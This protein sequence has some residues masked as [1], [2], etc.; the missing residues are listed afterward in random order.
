MLSTFTFSGIAYGQVGVNTSNPQTALHVDGAKD[1]PLTGAPSAAQQANDFAVNAAGN[2]GIGTATP[3]TRLDIENGT[4]AGAIKI[5]DGTQGA[6][7]VLT[8]DANGVG[9]WA[10]LPISYQN[11]ASYTSTSVTQINTWVN[12]NIS[13]TVPESGTYYINFNSRAWIIS[14]STNSGNGFWWKSQLRNSAGTAL[15]MVFGT[16]SYYPYDGDVTSS[17]S[18]VSH[19]NKNDVLSL[20]FYGTA[21]FV[22]GGNTDG[23]SS[24]T[25]FRLGS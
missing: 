11:T 14:N 12:S 15:G 7:K 2:V 21:P 20:W 3:A 5:V 4:T 17:F 13:V 22:Y 24:I 8:S 1:N 18:C 25:I 9:T 6:N 19:L 16:W 10:S 23:A